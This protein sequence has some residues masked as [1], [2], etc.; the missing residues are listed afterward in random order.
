MGH[1]HEFDLSE[2]QRDAWFEQIRILRTA[3]APHQGTIHLE[4]SIPRMGRRV[5]AVALIGPVVFVV[6]FKVGETRFLLADLDQV[7]D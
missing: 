3:L 7:V 1:R 2:T 4:F 6:E 5:D